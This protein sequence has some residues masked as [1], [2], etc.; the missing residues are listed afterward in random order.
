[1]AS[2][3]VANQKAWTVSVR[4]PTQ[5]WRAVQ[6]WG[7]REV[8]G[9]PRPRSECRSRPPPT[10]AGRDHKNP[11]LEQGLAPCS[12]LLERGTLDRREQSVHLT[13]P[14]LPASRPSES[15]ASAARRRSSTASA[16]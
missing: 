11:N 9:A 10:E 12:L 2:A 7:G 13:P 14:W 16:S 1:M 5:R 6:V 8:S 4:S 15:S 3:T